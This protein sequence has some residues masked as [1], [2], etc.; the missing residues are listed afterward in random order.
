[1]TETDD[2]GRRLRVAAG[3]AGTRTTRRRI[4]GCQHWP[5]ADQEGGPDERWRAWLA[6]Y[7]EGLRR[8]GFRYQLQFRIVPRTSQPLY[9]LYGTGDE[10]GGVGVMKDAMWEA[11]GNDG[12]GFQDPRTQGAPLPG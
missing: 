4:R 5:P 1:M 7:Q 11:E 12:I 9:L 3:K 8:A 2:F 6:T 10:K